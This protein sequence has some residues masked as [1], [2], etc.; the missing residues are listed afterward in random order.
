MN[1]LKTRA[2]FSKR[3]RKIIINVKNANRKAGFLND[4]SL[5]RETRKEK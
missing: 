2:D 4:S 3:V 1:T 5:S